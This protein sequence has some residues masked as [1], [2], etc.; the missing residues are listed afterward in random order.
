MSER[1]SLIAGLPWWR[2]D[3]ADKCIKAARAHERE[4]RR[5][6]SLSEKILHP[7]E[8]VTVEPGWAGTYGVRFVGPMVDY[9][10]VERV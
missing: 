2:R 6:R 9:S 8:G 5:F 4:A 10:K 3:M 7:P 1:A